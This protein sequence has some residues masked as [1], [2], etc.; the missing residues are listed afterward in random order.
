MNPGVLQ[1]IV[2][3]VL[4]FVTHAPA[5]AIP[6]VWV[7][8]LPGMHQRAT[9]VT[10]VSESIF[11]CLPTK[12]VRLLEVLDG[13]AKFRTELPLS[14]GGYTFVTWTSALLPIFM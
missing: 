11:T 13:A 12:P 4:P 14:S 1:D 6:T 2:M 10:V 9:A 5:V 7:W 8:E 3:L